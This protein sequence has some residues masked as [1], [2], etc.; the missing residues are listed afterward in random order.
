MEL[1]IF[2]AKVFSIY[3]VIISLAMFARPNNFK[4][5]AMDLVR[6][7]GALFISMFIALILGILLI[8]SHNVWVMGWPVLITILG[9]IVF[10]KGLI[11]L[12]FPELIV[13]MTKILEK[14]II[15]F[16]IAGFNLLLG[17]VLTYYGFFAY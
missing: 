14:Q 13:D 9:W 1:S 6:E 3:L 4:D 2:L 10:A 16:S 11:R 8:V 12:F 5:L 15:Y 7:P 17:F